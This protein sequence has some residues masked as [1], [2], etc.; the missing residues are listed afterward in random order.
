MSRT[1]ATALVLVNWRGV[2]YERY[3]LD[4]HVTALEGANGAGKTTVMIAA[5]VALLPDLTR[6]R[7]T[8]LGETGATGGD[9]GIWGRLGESGR[10]SYTVLQ[11]RLPDGSALLAGVHLERKAEPSLEVTPFIVDPW[12]GTAR[13]QE[14]LLQSDG[15]HD[16][17][18]TLAELRN[19]AK[20]LGARLTVFASAK[21]Y[22]SVLFERGVTPMR[23]A[24]D[25]SR[26][27]Y[28]EMLRTSM[29]GGISRALT[30]Q[31]RTFVL[32]EESALSD[33]LG[34][35]RGNLSACR[36]TRTEVQESRV[37]EHEICGIFDAGQ[38][39]FAAAWCALRAA[40]REHNLRIAGHRRRAE[41]LAMQLAKLERDLTAAEGHKGTRAAK[42]QGAREALEAARV[43]R[44]RLVRAM[45]LQDRWDALAKEVGH[46]ATIAEA[47][48][49]EHRQITEIRGRAREALLQCQDDFVRSAQSL[50]DLQAGLD[51]LHRKAHAHRLAH[52]KLEAL[53]EALGR[54][55]FDLAD[56]PEVRR[57]LAEERHEVDQALAVRD[58]ERSSAV[59]RRAEY[60]TARAALV[61]IAGELA[62]DDLHERARHE[63]R[64]LRQLE[65][66]ALRLVELRRKGELLAERL[67]RREA[68][69]ERL[70][71]VELDE[72][73][74]DAPGLLQLLGRL[75][76]EVADREEE[77]RQH[78]W[79][80][81]EAAQQAE[82]VRRH[83]GDLEAREH[84]WSRIR[85]ALD[86]VEATGEPLEPTREALQQ[87]R[88]E[89]VARQS[90]LQVRVEAC[91]SER[92]ALQAE[93]HALESSEAGGPSAALLEL[94]EQLD[95]EFL[96]Q[97][98]EELDPDEARRV[99]A[100]LGPL[101]DALV[102]EDLAAAA[103]SIQ[104]KG[105]AV[106]E[107]WIVA[108]DVDPCHTLGVSQVS[109]A[110]ELVVV[111][112]SL[113]L[114][115]TR[116]P[117]QARLGRQARQRRVGE[118]RRQSEQLATVM[119]SIHAE[120]RR[121]SEV[122]PALE[123]LDA[124]LSTWL[125][126]A[127][128]EVLKEARARL[129]AL[130]SEEQ[131]ARQRAADARTR[132]P[133]ARAQAQHL[134]ALLPE[135]NVLDGVVERE[136]FVAFEAEL[137]QAEGAREELERVGAARETLAEGLET[138]RRVPPSDAELAAWAEQREEL[139]ARRDRCHSLLETATSLELHGSALAWDDAQ[140]VLADRRELV[141]EL[142]EQHARA[143]QRLHAAKT[144][145]ERREA[146]WEVA[147]E[148]HRNILAA[149]EAAR[150]HH[151]RVG[152]ELEAEGFVAPSGEELAAL[153][154]EIETSAKLVLALE[155]E[156]RSRET[157]LALD[158]DRC[159]RLG[160]AV[161]S[162][163]HELEIA[164][165]AAKPAALAW[166][167]MQRRMEETGVL[168][169]GVHDVSLDTL[170]SANLWPEAR[171]KSALLLDR[172]EAARGGQELAK[173]LRQ[174][175][176]G[177]GELG[178]TYL[179]VWLETQE[180]LRKRLPS[181]IAEGRDPLAGL[182]QLREDLSRL[183]VR[184][185]RQEEDLRGTSEDVA[186]SIDVQIRRAANQVE[187][188]NRHLAGV[189]FGSIE[190]IRI[191]MHRVENMEP[192]LAALRDGSAQ[193]L[194]F[195]SAMSI[196]DAMEE[197]FRRY[198]GGGRAGAQRILDY[199]EYI[200]LRVEVL[201]R[202]GDDWELA[203]PTR[204][205]TGEAI[206][207][208]A[209]LMMVILAE[210]ERDANLLRAQKGG[211]CLRF[212]FLDEANR[213]S[214]DNLA[215][216]FDLCEKLDLQLLIAAPEVAHAEGN[217]TYRLVR[218]QLEDGR[219]EVLVSGRRGSMPPTMNPALEANDDPLPATEE[220]TSV[221]GAE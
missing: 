184:L 172:L 160:D 54:P 108:A 47:S 2:F 79:R 46:H 82:H 118:L 12:D 189:T 175:L 130:Q 78:T 195:H 40:A 117:E 154:E 145:L 27:K 71:A 64:R 11:L 199:R 124:G 35:M 128:A 17:I 62:D 166:S 23:M 32:K 1:L 29:T 174:R 91:E 209:A 141:P 132:I 6:L 16:E 9:R 61:A 116:V 144:E 104:K 193:Q 170:D 43:R 21:E 169:L 212:L 127:P 150:A 106:D 100:L 153:D 133:A 161:R 18:P 55:D 200:D 178:E 26:N 25:E 90:R 70:R 57:A 202:A 125:A 221:D 113:G 31:L 187:R 119:E 89:L 30:S 7:F 58:R 14:L 19:H 111:E 95:A 163:E 59:H 63:L 216:L 50:A 80:A 103:T 177:E 173:L 76:A 75:D 5:Y 74:E 162:E 83:I 109:S 67:E 22:F 34:R 3:L 219:E 146:E 24:L 68:F 179:R 115:V 198:G 98:Y 73:P 92:Q 165:D 203:N 56:L 45:T 97:R 77:Q 196:E 41:E 214:Q 139:E 39:T 105:T 171:S 13:L 180:W 66:T 157:Q 201:R 85:R 121:A 143:E 96:A 151:L 182:Q 60:D 81:R 65:T 192:V 220:Q 204:V 137:Q 188:L 114:R 207:V 136:A 158:R 69:E 138:L 134:R 94:R 168:A 129:E 8:N 15:E 194:L 126:G 206:G 84:Q 147:S 42:L 4:R 140:H 148:A 52:E 190:G 135:A 167:H 217:T 176:D 72:V 99:Q 156:E 191:Q 112:S 185:A 28:N 93:A 36:K 155:T 215:V 87:R 123:T 10:P 208:G 181:H 120:L 122:L 210:W 88:S 53:R 186:H 48:G 20:R 33:T 102:V 107:A 159:S 211:G 213:L 86:L 37:L 49:R 101:I 110:S 131:E 152:H 44:E 142:R 218:R 197:I 183:E 205:S 51:E 164:E 38:A 149:Y